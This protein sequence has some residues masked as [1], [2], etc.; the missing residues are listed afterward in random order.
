M[1]NTFKAVIIFVVGVLLGIT[2]T[3][4]YIHHCFARARVNSG[5][6]KHIVDMLD[7]K[8][9]LTEDQ[10]IKIEKVF[11]DA[12][13]SMEAIRVETNA[14]LKMTRD[15]ISNQVRSLLTSDQQQKYDILH[16]EWV[17]KMNANDRGWH[18]PGLPHDGPPP[19]PGGPEAPAFPNPDLANPALK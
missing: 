19:P 11:D 1:N 13:P 2:G 6:H 14:K 16:A 3:G 4:F 8:L 15:N 18:I 9:S 10:K 12:A 17:K 5:N 7:S